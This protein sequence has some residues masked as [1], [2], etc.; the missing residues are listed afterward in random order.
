MLI[1]ANA[2]LEILLEFGM[3]Y[4][5]QSLAIDKCHLLIRCYTICSAQ[6]TI[7]NKLYTVRNILYTIYSI[8]Y[9]IYSILY[10]I[11]N[12]LYMVY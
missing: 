9:T 1:F 5:C 8:L 4:P 7:Y 12:I 11:H 10:I 6:F 3:R 2:M